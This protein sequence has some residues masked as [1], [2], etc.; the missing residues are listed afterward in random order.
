MPND[1]LRAYLDG[2]REL[3]DLSPSAR[4]RARAWDE[5]VEEVRVATGGDAA[6]PDHLE[7]RVMRSLPERPDLPLWRRALEWLLRPRTVR[8]S[9][10]A[11]AGVAVA[12]VLAVL[13]PA[14]W[15]SPAGTGA[16]DGTTAG[17]SPQGRNGAASTV[18]AD[19]TG[20]RAGEGRVYVRF[21]LRAPDARSVAVAGDFT[22]WEPGHYLSDADGDG[23]WTGR[24]PLQPGLHQ[25]MFVVDGSRW[26]TDPGAERYV[27]DGFG[28]RNAVVTISST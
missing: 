22:N 27:D 28:H 24:V 7:R 11:G 26:V 3:A 21:E 8:V 17:P 9:P 23:V 20:D 13:V 6:A 1:E 2:E 10:L 18:A 16:G 5:L 19:G 12:L 15:L 25:Y 14:V 4:E